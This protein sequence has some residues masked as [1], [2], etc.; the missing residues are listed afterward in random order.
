[1]YIYTV[2]ILFIYKK[3]QLQILHIDRKYKFFDKTLIFLISLCMLHIEYW[4]SLS[5]YIHLS[6]NRDTHPLDMYV[7]SW[8]TSPLFNTI[9]HCLASCSHSLS[10][11]QLKECIRA[12]DQEQRHTPFRQSKLTQVLRDSFLGQARTCMI[13][14]VSPNAS[15]VD[16]TLN[17]LRYADRYIHASCTDDNEKYSVKIHELHLNCEIT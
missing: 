15:A 9:A 12:L 11:S 7:A 13:A 16:H 17:T 3:L 2:I 5:K 1:M 6:K 14:C 4:I 8:S 10:P